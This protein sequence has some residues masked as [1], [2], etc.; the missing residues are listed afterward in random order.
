MTD[1]IA[2]VRALR[3]LPP[4]Q[5]AREIRRAAGVSRDRLADELGV[6]VITL[7]RWERG[8][9]RPQRRYRH[10]YAELL[11]ALAAEVSP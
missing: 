8:M 10:R 1:L 5:L 4:P 6:H 3:Q 9:S 2:E 11:A 7:A